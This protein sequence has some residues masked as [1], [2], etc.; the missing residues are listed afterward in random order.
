[1]KIYIACAV[2]RIP[3]YNRVRA[4]IEAAG[5]TITFPWADT[6]L[7]ALDGKDKDAEHKH[8]R[9]RSRLDIQ[10]VISAD[11]VVALLPARLGTHVEIGAAIA[12]GI[13]VIL[14]AESED[15]IWK[16][17]GGYTCA[18]YHSAY[19]FWATMPFHLFV[20]RIAHVASLVVGRPDLRMVTD[21]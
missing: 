1:M 5:H 3:D 15:E 18:F 11:C 7:G 9:E 6:C 16:P 21:G 14:H 20:E 13:P 10:G 17:M 2:T 4:A 19:A 8:L 12:L